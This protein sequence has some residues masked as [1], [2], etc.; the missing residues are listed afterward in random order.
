MMFNFSDKSYINQLFQLYNSLSIAKINAKPAS[1]IPA[2]PNTVTNIIIPSP[3]TAAEPI[4][5]NV[6]II[7]SLKSFKIPGKIEK[8]IKIF[9]NFT[10][11]KTPMVFF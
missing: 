8:Y 2:Y 7:F 11:K 9:V 4:L 5:A 1:G 3:G 10:N 6:M